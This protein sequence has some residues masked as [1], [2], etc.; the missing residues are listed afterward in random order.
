[1]H[2]GSGYR[3]SDASGLAKLAAQQHGVVAL[4]E[5]EALGFTKWP[6]QR[7]VETALLHRLHRAVYAVGHTRL[8]TRGRWMAAVLACGPQAVLSHHAAVALWELR[9][10]PA[11]AIDVTVPVKRI[12]TGVRC[13][14]VKALPAPD[15]TILD[16]IP[17]TT[18]TG[19]C[20]SPGR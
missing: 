16:A 5:L 17:V 9:P 18:L 11:A 2:S 6:V 4:Y 15:R 14:V 13:H 3:T 7:R 20:A 1:M 12:H 10:N 19:S 8:T